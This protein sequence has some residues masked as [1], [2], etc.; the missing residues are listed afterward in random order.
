MDK[1]YKVLQD[2]AELLGI[3]QNQSTEKL[4]A[5]IE[6]A[7]TPAAVGEL[8]GRCKTLNE[9]CKSVDELN[10]R[11]G[12]QAE[13]NGIG[14]DIIEK[15]DE[16]HEAQLAD[17]NVYTEPYLTGMANQTLIVRA[18]VTGEEMDKE[19]LIKPITQV[20][21]GGA[22]IPTQRER[23]VA[24]A[25]KYITIQKGMAQLRTGLTVDDIKKAD[26]IMVALGGKA[27]VYT[28]P[29]K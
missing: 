10:T 9:H 3:K 8:I 24:A 12:R 25:G 13:A 23:L 28:L 15:L 5:A 4:I 27:G 19:K 20:D 14:G 1:T 18:I 11:L 7:T 17:K 16:L 2:E 29:Q 26:E 22:K 21:V 6:A